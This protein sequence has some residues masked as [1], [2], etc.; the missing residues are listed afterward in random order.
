M[1]GRSSLFHQF[2]RAAKYSTISAKS[3]FI[4]ERATRNGVDMGCSF[5]SFCFLAGNF[6][7]RVFFLR[8]L[9]LGVIPAGLR[10]PGKGGPGRGRAVDPVKRC[11]RRP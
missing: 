6:G 3:T 10:V 11:R 1:A 4:I 9:F 7:L 5:R 2:S 8:G